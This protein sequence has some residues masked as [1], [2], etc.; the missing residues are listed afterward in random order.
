MTKYLSEQQIIEFIGEIVFEKGFALMSQDSYNESLI[1]QSIKDTGRVKELA[2]AATNMAVVGYG[3]KRYGSY[4]IDDKIFDIALLLQDCGVKTNLP[5]DAKLKESDLTPGRL[6]RF[7]R[8]EIKRFLIETKQTSYLFRKY[9]DKNPKFSHICF[10]GSEYLDNLTKDE[11]EFLYHTYL[12][13]DIDRGLE[14]SK[15]IRRVFEAK[16]YFTT[17]LD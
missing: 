6:C 12:K 17:N 9:S 5:R 2:M 13:L 4:R 3:N 7:F 11:V 8:N 10:R 16:A 1:A 15:R 14:I